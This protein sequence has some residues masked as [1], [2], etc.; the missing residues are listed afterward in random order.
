MG[1]F[2]DWLYSLSIVQQ[3]WIGVVIAF[4]CAMATLGVQAKEWLAGAVEEAG[5][6][7]VVMTLVLMGIGAGMALLWPLTLIYTAAMFI[8]KQFTKN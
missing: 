1:D 2:V 7:P 3:Y 5:V 4:I 6:S 8:H